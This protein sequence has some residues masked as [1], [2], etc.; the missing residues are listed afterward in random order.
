MTVSPTVKAAALAEGP[1]TA[2][3]ELLGIAKPSMRHR[4][5]HSRPTAAS[6]SPPPLRTFCTKAGLDH[7][8]EAASGDCS[9][10]LGVQ[11]RRCSD[12]G[13]ARP[14]CCLLGR[15]AAVGCRW[16]VARTVGFA[17]AVGAVLVACHDAADPLLTHVR[18]APCSTAQCLGQSCRPGW[19]S[20]S[21]TPCCR[22]TTVTASTMN[23]AA[24][25]GTRSAAWSSWLVQSLYT[26]IKCRLAHHRSIS[27]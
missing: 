27:S 23:M 20:L 22:C 26:P 13:C 5:S 2:L 15:P 3:A 21:S 14:S 24:S 1:L 8:G 19:P 18:L 12:C 25:T 9:G 6:P 7:Q 4:H 16:A 11:G 10:F 17:A